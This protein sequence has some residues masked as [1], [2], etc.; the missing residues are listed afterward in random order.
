MGKAPKQLQ[1]S[2]LLLERFEIYL[3]VLELLSQFSERINKTFRDAS[4]LKRRY[5]WSQFDPLGTFKNFPLLAGLNGWRSSFDNWQMRFGLAANTDFEQW[6]N[7]LENIGEIRKRVLD[8]WKSGDLKIL[9]SIGNEAYKPLS[10][11]SQ[12]FSEDTDLIGTFSNWVEI[13]DKEKVK[14]LKQIVPKIKLKIHELENRVKG[15][16]EKRKVFGLTVEGLSNEIAKSMEFERGYSYSKGALV[17][18]I[19]PG[20]GYDSGIQK[21]DIITAVNGQEIYYF[22]SQL[23][24]LETNAMPGQTFNFQVFRNGQSINLKGPRFVRKQ[25]VLKIEDK[26]IPFR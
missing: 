7:S 4:A 3:E 20:Y 22:I 18:N 24:P 26:I 25:T 9:G 19:E 2:K 17:K 15:G 21:N 11:L 1:D 16:S 5:Y 8:S 12:Y 14:L 13:S 23:L 6:M 10:Q